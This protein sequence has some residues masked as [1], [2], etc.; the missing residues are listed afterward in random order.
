MYFAFC[1]AIVN[2]VCITTSLCYYLSKSR[3][4]FSAWVVLAISLRDM[5]AKG[6]LWPWCRSEKKLASLMKYIIGTGFLTVIWSICV[7]ATVRDVSRSKM[8]II[9]LCVSP[10]VRN[11]AKE[12]HFPCFLWEL[13]EEYAFLV[14]ACLTY[15][16]SL[17]S[18][19]SSSLPQCTPCHVERA[20]KA[21]KFFEL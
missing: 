13:L 21:C 8:L 1:G 20:W 19:N 6:M 17:S 9:A 18:H 5:L 16:D 3:T 14:F 11:H 15:S 12:L 10:I 7:L 4:G 2:N